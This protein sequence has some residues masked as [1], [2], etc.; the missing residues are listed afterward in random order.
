VLFSFAVPLH[1]WF[2]FTPTTDAF[3]L[4]PAVTFLRSGCVSA[5]NRH[6]CPCFGVGFH[7]PIDLGLCYCMFL[8]EAV[9]RHSDAVVMCGGDA[10]VV[11]VIQLWWGW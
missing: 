1:H 2:A 6:L 10:V 4:S 5:S 8:G 7:L 3:S 11:E 9:W